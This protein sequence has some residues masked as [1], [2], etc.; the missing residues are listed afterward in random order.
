M[1]EI[2]EIPADRLSILGLLLGI[3][4]GKVDKILAAPVSNADSLMK[5]EN[6]VEA[7]LGGGK[8][9]WRSLVEQLKHSLLK[10]NSIANS[11]EVKY[12]T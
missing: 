3:S 10:L 1:T 5:H 7:W 2:Q 4:K 8:A 6:I 9:T 12:V 11:I